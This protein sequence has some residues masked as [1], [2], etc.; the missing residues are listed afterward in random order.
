MVLDVSESH[1]EAVKVMEYL[2]EGHDISDW[3]PDNPSTVIFGKGF[4][5]PARKVLDSDTDEVCAILLTN[6]AQLF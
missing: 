4:R 2:L 6:L 5:E 3:R 1:Q